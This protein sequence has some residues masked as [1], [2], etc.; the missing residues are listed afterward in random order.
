MRKAQLLCVIPTLGTGG[1]EQVLLT[2][3]KFLDRERF[4]ATLAVADL[5]KA[6]R[7][8]Q[9]PHDVELVDLGAGRVRYAIPRILALAWSRRPD[10]ILSTLGHLNMALGFCRRLLPPRIRVVARESSIVSKRMTEYPA[11][12]MMR[13]LA[14]G[15]YRQFDHI[16]CQSNAMQ[17]DL[18]ANFGILPTRSSVIRNPLDV[19]RIRQLS[20]V[21]GM[22]GYD[23]GCTNLVAVGR[24][25]K[26]KRFDRLLEAFALAAEADWRL[27]IV[28]GGLELGALDEQISALSL[29]NKVRLVGQQ[30]NPYPFIAGADALVLSSDYEGLPNVIL[31]AMACGTPVVAVPAPGG[32]PEILTGVAGCFLANACTSESLASALT[33]WAQSARQRLGTGAS[34]PY[35]ANTISRLYEAVLAQVYR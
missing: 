3:L 16:I 2:L 14:R 24:L 28:G 4:T 10:I 19:A 21:P 20:R 8:T 25:S 7:R 11:P 15:S 6:V 23:R 33:A 26:V 17:D 32:T 30:E 12:A 13:A 5:T 18:I 35:E 1:S 29:G 27:T 31:E 22:H 9:V 34:E